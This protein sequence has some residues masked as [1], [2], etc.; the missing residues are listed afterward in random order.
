MPLVFV[1]R[2]GAENDQLTLLTPNG[3]IKG[4][5]QEV[6]GGGGATSFLDL[7]DTPASY[8]GAGLF[9]VR[10]DAG[11]IALEFS[12]FPAGGGDLQSS[13]ELGNT[14]VTSAAFGALDVSGTEPVNLAGDGMTFNSADFF[15]IFGSS[16]LTLASFVGG[17]SVIG[18]TSGSFIVNAGNLNL[19]AGSG[20]G[21][22]E[23]DGLLQLRSATGILDLEG[24]AGISASA[25]GAIDLTATGAP[26]T[27]RAL[28]GGSAQ[29]L[30]AGTGD[31]VIEATGGAVDIDGDTGVTIDSN[32]AIDITANG[33]PAS[34][35][36]VGG[37]SAQVLGSAAS[38]IAG[39]TLSLN[40]GAGTGAAGE[41]L[42]A[43]GIGG[44][45][46]QPGGGGGGSMG[47]K[48]LFPTALVTQQ[49]IPWSGAGG[50][51]GDLYLASVVPEIDTDPIIDMVL[52]VSQAPGG[53]GGIAAGIYDA[54][55]NRL[56]YSAI[57]SPAV[58]IVTLPLIVGAGTVLSEGTQYFFA[59]YSNQ[60]GTRIIGA[61][62]LTG[63]PAGLNLG[64]LVV[65]SGGIDVSGFPANVAGFFGNQTTQRY[66]ANATP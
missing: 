3:P 29:L 66:Y 20:S 4:E 37:G 22:F 48:E 28:L 42:T 38:L 56:A 9:A 21:S 40:D 33:A 62:G 12:P 13:Y 25:N 41:V 55:G 5:L 16:G 63:V 44:A 17:V 35:R 32:G 60:N 19:S 2:V 11:E 59:V 58:G 36:A 30:A 24:D 57:T 8:A 49:N 23:T 31:A 15:N 51:L 47:G 52:G 45:S 54:A 43:D 64:F 61:T 6:S 50:G 7:S 14:I 10:V 46:W 39:A 26:A 27:L 53:A 1:P 65:N 34:L 18:Q